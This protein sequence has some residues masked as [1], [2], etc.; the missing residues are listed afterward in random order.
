[1]KL[2]NKDISMNIKSVILPKKLELIFV[3]I[4]LIFA[5]LLGLYSLKKNQDIRNQASGQS[6]E[7]QI[8]QVKNAEDYIKFD[9]KYINLTEPNEGN[10]SYLPHQVV[11]PDVVYIKNGWNGYKYWLSVSPFP[12]LNP[13]YEDPHIF[14]S[15]DGYSW[16]E[17]RNKP[18]VPLIHPRQFEYSD[19]DLVFDSNKLWLYY[20]LNNKNGSFDYADDSVKLYRISSSD[21]VNW[22]I[23][24][25]TNLHFLPSGSFASPTIAKDGSSFVLFYVNTIKDEMHRLESNDGINWSKDEVVFSLPKIWHLDVFKHQD[26]YI[27]LINEGPQANKPKIYYLTSKNTYDWENQGILLMPSAEGW[28]STRLYRST[29]LI[30]GSRFRLWYSAFQNNLGRTGYTEDNNFQ[31]VKKKVPSCKSWSDVHINSCDSIDKSMGNDGDCISDSLDVVINISSSNQPTHMKIMRA[32]PEEWCS[33]ININDY[34]WSK[35]ED[36]KTRKTWSFD[37]WGEKKICVALKN[38]G[39]WGVPC[40]GSISLVNEN[41]P[42]SNTPE[43]SVTEQPTLPPISNTPEPS[44]TEQPTLPPPSEPPI[45]KSWS[46]IYVNNCNTYEKFSERFFGCIVDSKNITLHINAINSPK[47]MKIIN[48]NPE[49][50]CNSLEVNDSRWSQVYDYK[51]YFNW[52]L[53][54]GSGEKKVCVVMKNEQ[55]WGDPCGAKIIVE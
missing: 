11:H 43:P 10:N 52:V 47:K 28:D 42:I 12:N 51:S 2:R 48:V 55:G 53:S 38:E 5:L 41:K 24:E 33:Q 31:F 49:I 7:Y 37:Q 3:F 27:A 39:G 1:M 35:L 29:A 20:R 23:P 8:P 44:V 30:E 21:G 9:V 18:V 32:S 16:I 45:C 25:A 6:Y 13:K 36:Y 26:T 40:G 19:A 17:P 50:W 54:K 14:A 15:N 22:T 46:D 34:R 4:V